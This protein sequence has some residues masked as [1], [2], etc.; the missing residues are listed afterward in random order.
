MD[1]RQRHEFGEAAGALL[2][3]ANADQMPGPVPG[4][5]DVSVT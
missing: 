2:Q 5:V 4:L 3:V 1:E